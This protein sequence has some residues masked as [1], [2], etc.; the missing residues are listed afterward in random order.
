MVMQQAGN[1]MS[2]VEIGTAML[3]ILDMATDKT[4]DEVSTRLLRVV[5]EVEQRRLSRALSECSAQSSE[6]ASDADEKRR[7]ITI[8]RKES[9]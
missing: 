9:S 4:S 7:R 1:G 3:W 2:L 5:E 6:Q 8:K